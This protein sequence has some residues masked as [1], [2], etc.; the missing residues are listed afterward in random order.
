MLDLEVLDLSD[1]EFDG[2]IPAMVEE[3]TSL[4]A[5]S[6]RSNMF[7]GIIPTK[8]TPPIYHFYLWME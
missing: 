3:W 6:L 7:S 4:K 8:G 2:S 5:L 1:N